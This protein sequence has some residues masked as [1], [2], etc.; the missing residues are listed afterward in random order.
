MQ[1][2]SSQVCCIVILNCI[3]SLAISVS[4]V[5]RSFWNSCSLEVVWFVHVLQVEQGRLLHAVAVL[6]LGE[7][8]HEAVESEGQCCFFDLL[9]CPGAVAMHVPAVLLPDGSLL[10]S[11]D[12]RCL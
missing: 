5:A 2:I 4:R 12:R 11:A 9:V 7:H 3:C 8:E 6:A 1:K 10:C